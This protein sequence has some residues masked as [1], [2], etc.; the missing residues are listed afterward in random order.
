M[1]YRCNKR[2]HCLI[3]KMCNYVLGKKNG[4][5]VYA[6]TDFFSSARLQPILELTKFIF[7][8]VIVLPYATIQI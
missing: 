3:K 6:S 7:I 1:F 4:N 2:N 8:E 5:S